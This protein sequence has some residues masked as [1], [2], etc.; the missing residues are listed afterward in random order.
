MDG[1]AGDGGNGGRRAVS[2]VGDHPGRWRLRPRQRA[3]PALPGRA[4][5]RPPAGAVPR[6]GRAASARG[7]LS[8]LGIDGAGRPHRRPLPERTV[9]AGCARPRRHAP[10]AA[11]HAR[12]A[13]R[14]PARERRRL[15]RRRAGRTPPL[16]P[17]RRRRLP[18]RGVLA[19]G[20][21]GAVLQPAQDVRGPARC[22]V[23]GRRGERT[24]HARRLRRLGRCA[25][26][27]PG[28]RA[29]AAHPRHRA[30]RHERGPGR[31]CR[32]HR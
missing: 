28:R 8:Q 27:R 15:P 10:A 2:A 22:V 1:A 30:R 13:G 5:H 16:G 32:D 3:E 21:L 11:G 12:R 29:A 20:R 7:Q 18:G 14:M 19:G 31:R 26:G 4:R 24:R 17:H 6:R 25:G 9:A 23:G